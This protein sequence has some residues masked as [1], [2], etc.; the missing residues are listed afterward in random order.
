MTVTG[1]ENIFVT[2]H[3]AHCIQK[4]LIVK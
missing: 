2:D 3:Y 1:D 4:Y